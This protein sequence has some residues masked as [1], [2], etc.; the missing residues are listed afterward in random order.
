MENKLKT[1]EY[2]NF[3]LYF[4]DD[5]FFEIAKKIID[6][7]IVVKKELKNTKRNYVVTFEENGKEY[8]LKEPRNEFRIIQRK[9]LTFFK[10]GEALN[11][12]LNVNKLIEKYNFKEYIKPFLAIVKRKNGMIIYSAIISEYVE[13]EIPK[14]NAELQKIV[15]LMIKIHSKGFYHGDF[16]PTN[17]I[18]KNNTV[19]ILDTQAK[20]RG[21]TKYRLHYDMLTMKMDSFPNMIYPYKKFFSFYMA[22]AMKKFKRLK[23]VQK[24]KKY[25]KSKRDRNEN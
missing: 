16:N 2:K 6:K 4:F 20:K 19:Y 24:I 13:G 7:K 18:I 8:V 17:F 9:I 1:M 15:D 25:R 12:L 10:K 5:I 23:F 22:L 11:T 14:T 21:L 3:K